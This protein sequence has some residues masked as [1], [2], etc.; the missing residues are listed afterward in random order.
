ML[1]LNAKSG[2]AMLTFRYTLLQYCSYSDLPTSAFVVTTL[3]LTK[4]VNVYESVAGKNSSS[5]SPGYSASPMRFR[6]VV[7]FP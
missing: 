6:P 7:V 4:Y 5:S 1:K 3:D 2:K